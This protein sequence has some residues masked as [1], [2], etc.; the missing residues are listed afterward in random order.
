MD[1]IGPFAGGMAVGAIVTVLALLSLGIFAYR[2]L[3]GL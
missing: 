1:W 3:A 2:K